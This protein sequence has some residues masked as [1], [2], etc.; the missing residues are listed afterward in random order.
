M[1]FAFV[2]AE[3]LKDFL[4]AK[5]AWHA[6]QRKHTVPSHLYSMALARG[7]SPHEEMVLVTDDQGS[8]T[9]EIDAKGKSHHDLQERDPFHDQVFECRQRQLVVPG[10]YSDSRT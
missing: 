9:T 6:L 10:K 5:T 7:V 4:E 2:G 1:S 3:V 8:Y